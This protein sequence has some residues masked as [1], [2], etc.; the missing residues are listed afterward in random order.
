M[1]FGALSSSRKALDGV[2]KKPV[3][4]YTQNKKWNEWR[5]LFFNA[6]HSFSLSPFFRWLYWLEV[7][8]CAR[9]VCFCARGTERK[10]FTCRR[11]S[12]ASSS[13]WWKKRNRKRTEI[14]F[15]CCNL[16]WRYAFEINRFQIQSVIAAPFFL[17][18]SSLAFLLHHTQTS[19]TDNEAID[20]ADYGRYHLRRARI[21]TVNIY[22]SISN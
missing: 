7:R 11:A 1:H 4:T 2:K 16:T 22:P 8:P 5:N 3:C 19:H 12:N 15:L 18:D 21:N 17:V 14:F 10:K 13:E 20:S 6:S 9:S